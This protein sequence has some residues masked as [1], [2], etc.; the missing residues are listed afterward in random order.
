MI[1]GKLSADTLEEIRLYATKHDRRPLIGVDRTEAA[2][3]TL[4]LM[5][6]PIAQTS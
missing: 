1:G 2:A 6:S 3:S 4:T 5:P